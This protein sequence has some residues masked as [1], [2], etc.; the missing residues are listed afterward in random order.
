[1]DCPNCQTI[2]KEKRWVTNSFFGDWV[3]FEM[4]SY[5]LLI[6]LLLLGLVGWVVFVSIFTVIVVMSWGKRWYKCKKCGYST[7]L[8]VNEI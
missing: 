1:M 4:I 2:L 6:P 3:A 7:M 8:K 5:I